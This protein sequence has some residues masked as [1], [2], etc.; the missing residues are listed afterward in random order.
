MLTH[1]IKAQKDLLYATYLGAPIPSLNVT[2]LSYLFDVW[3]KY[4]IGA[5][6]LC[7]TKDMLPLMTLNGWT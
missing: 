2:Y 7:L 4:V 6:W 1:E 3:Q 5:G